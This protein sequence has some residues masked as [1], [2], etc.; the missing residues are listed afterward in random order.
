MGIGY[1]RGTV[2][3]YRMLVERSVGKHA[4]GRSRRCAGGVKVGLREIGFEN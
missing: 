4:V 3:A 1:Y 2:C